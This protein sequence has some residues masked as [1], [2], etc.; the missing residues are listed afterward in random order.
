MPKALIFECQRVQPAALSLLLDR[1]Y[2]ITATKA[3]LHSFRH[4]RSAEII[5][6]PVEYRFGKAER[7]SFPN[8][9][10][11]ISASTTDRHISKDAVAGIQVVT[12]KNIPYEKLAKITPTME[13]TIGLIWAVT[14]HIVP[15]MDQ[16]VWTR[17]TAPGAKMWSR[18]S[19]ALLGKGRIAS[20][21]VPR[22]Q[23]LFHWV[24]QFS[25][26]NEF[27]GQIRPYDIVSLHLP[28]TDDGKPIIT[29]EFLNLQKCHY[30]INTAQGDMVDEQ[31][32]VGALKAGLLKGYAADC[33]AGEYS[34][35][36]DMRRSP[37][38]EAS[39]RGANI[40]LT[41]HIGGSTLDAWSETQC[42]VLAEAIR[43]ME[44]G[45]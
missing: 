36:F 12:L 23:G 11:L 18:S 43:L 44:I 35:K 33:L 7:A 9:R 17:Y 38:W 27:L 30:L 15:T 25:S 21:L 10:V 41:P 22:L 45:Q 40:I 4:D 2:E 6:W 20:G 32:V 8:L 37:F 42:L 29:E 19:I 26:F 39:N 28:P 16:G 31:A 5:L 1:G 14:R 24:T 13:H 3:P 34:P